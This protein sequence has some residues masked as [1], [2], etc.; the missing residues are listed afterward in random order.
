LL[1]R[2]YANAG[3]IPIIEYLGTAMGAIERF[4]S[5]ITWILAQ[6]I[7]KP[8]TAFPKLASNVIETI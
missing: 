2:S 1:L 4:A 7:Q 5:G 8:A 3:N 6:P